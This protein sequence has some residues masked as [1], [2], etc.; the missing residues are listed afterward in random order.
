MK[1]F[2]AFFIVSLIILPM[3]VLHATRLYQ[4]SGVIPNH[5]AE[6]V[7][8][9]NRNAS[10][11]A[12]AAYYNPAGLAFMGKSGLSV[13]FSSQTYNVRKEHTMDY[14]AI[15]VGNYNAVQTFHDR[16]SF[17]GEL[18]DYYYAETVA[19]VLPDLCIVYSDRT[20]GHDWAVY[21]H[22]GVMQASNGM[23]F[24]RGLA[25]ID[26][27]NLAAKE[28]QLA[29]NEAEASTQVFNSFSSDAKATRTEY[30]IGSAVGGVYR[31]L[32]WM[33]ASMGVR[34]I[35]YSGNMNIK[36][37]NI[38]YEIDNVVEK[39]PEN[40]W[41]IDTDYSGHGASMALGFHFKPASSLNIGFKY[42]YF[43]PVKMTKKTNHFHVNPLLET[44][45][46]LNIFKDGSA[47]KDMTY[48]S[49]NG[50]S[51]FMM[52]YPMQFNLGISYNILKNLKIETSGEITL[53]SLRRMD[54]RQK[55]YNTIGYRVGAA[56]EWWFIKN[57]CVSAGYS[58]NNFG[59]KENCRDEADPLL[60]SHTMG[61]GFG[62]VIND[63]FDVNIGA[64]Y[65]YCMHMET[66]TT[67]YTYV[68]DPTYH[69]LH[70]T[71]DEYRISVAL[72]LTYRFFGSP[73]EDEDNSK[74]K[75]RF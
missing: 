1:F 68:T 32:E 7:R 62:F 46:S 43:T 25:A 27:G 24:P 53:Q 6:Y 14:Y 34:Y 11:S 52:Q 44:S 72:G 22:I 57:I 69:Y 12:D 64:S 55:D 40:E 74:K 16:N 33:S 10:T 37:K 13:M 4:E 39:D 59:I 42:E 3:D 19:P 51:T 5:S 41:N 9:L 58:Y 2:Y 28:S 56:I 48:T 23:C 73:A 61:G 38:T 36:V 50:E 63:R 75:K 45:G 60:P 15:K 67:E 71:F 8:T 29:M 49:G 54:G 26:W 17:T 30:F 20:K 18:P 65:E 21:F 70:K 35:N 66:Y 31:I 47:G